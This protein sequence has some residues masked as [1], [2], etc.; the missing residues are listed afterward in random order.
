MCRRRCRKSRCREPSRRAHQQTCGGMCPRTMRCNGREVGLRAAFLMLAPAGRLAIW[1]KVT[2]VRRAVSSAGRAPALHAGCRRFESVTAH[3]RSYRS[4]AWEDGPIHSGLPPWSAL[5]ATIRG[6]PRDCLS[7]LIK[8]FNGRHEARH[9]CGLAG[10]ATAK[11]V[12]D[13]SQWPALTLDDLLRLVAVFTCDIIH[14]A[15]GHDRTS[16]GIN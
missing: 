8:C 6:G 11:A 14:G 5:T 2:R 10:G 12:D 15:V 1:G 3:H 7:W 16:S 9:S 4:C 13:P